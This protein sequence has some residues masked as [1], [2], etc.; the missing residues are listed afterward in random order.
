MR[1]PLNLAS[2]PVRNDRLPA[3]L[4]ALATVVLIGATLHHAV[5]LRRL[6]PGRSAALKKE[7]E[8]LGTE[9]KNLESGPMKPSVVSQPQNV[10]WRIIRELVDRRAF[11][12]SELFASFEAA[13]PPDVRITSVT[14]RV[15][16][17][18]YDVEVVAR[19]ASPQAGLNFLKVLEDRPEF[20]NVYPQTCSETQ[21]EYDCRY[22]MRYLGQEPE[23]KPKPAA[24]KSPPAVP[25]PPSGGL[26]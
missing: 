25:A 17:R 5:V 14:P 3:L 16:D 23:S 12:W 8:D 21:G 18:R 1:S 11:W 7:V 10:E 6:W 22:L 19:L 9:M 20:E 15:R 2:R 13:L 24:P 4:F 26:S